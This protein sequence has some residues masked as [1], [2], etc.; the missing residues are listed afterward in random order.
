MGCG[1]RR[2]RGSGAIRNEPEYVVDARGWDG[3]PPRPANDL[4]SVCGDPIFWGTIDGRLV[5]MDLMCGRLHQH[6]LEHPNTARLNRE[7][8]AGMRRNE[9]R[10]GP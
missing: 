1:R 9:G 4:C 2:K 10:D 7:R 3:S 5:A 8:I 6:Q